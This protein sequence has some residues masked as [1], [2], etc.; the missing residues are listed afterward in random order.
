MLQQ[1]GPALRRPQALHFFRG[2]SSVK[3]DGGQDDVAEL[4]EKHT[5]KTV[6]RNQDGRPRVVTTRREALALYRMALRWSNLF[7]WKDELGRPWRDVIRSS[8]RKEFEDARFEQDP[9]IIN[10]MIITGRD[11]VQ[12][13][14]DKFLQKREQLLQQDQGSNNPRQ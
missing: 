10:R 11:C 5:D 9:E 7:V 14:V 1:I 8:T 13:T 3:F 12:R 6:K 2:C 4:F